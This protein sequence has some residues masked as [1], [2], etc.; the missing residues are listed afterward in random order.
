[1]TNGTEIAGKARFDRIRYAQCWEDADVLLE[2]MQV[3]KGDTCLS[4]ASAGDNT[5][6]LAGAGAGRVIAVDLNPAQIA[7]LELRIAAYRELDHD[8]FLEI[9]GQSP[10][11]RREQLY[12]RCRR[13]LSVDSC[14]FWDCRRVLIRRGF[15]QVGKFERFLRSFRRYLLPLVE[16]RRNVDHL[17]ALRTSQERQAFYDSRWNNRRWRFLCRLFFGRAALGRFGRDPS[18]TRYADESVWAS[19]QRRIPQALVVQEPADNPYLQWILKG[20]Y[21]SALPWSWRRENFERIRRNLDAIEWHCEPIEQVLAGIPDGTLNGCNLSDIF[22]Y[23]SETAYRALLYEFIRASA[24]GCRLVYW[25]VVVERSRPE[26]FARALVPLKALA[27]RLHAVDKA[28]FYRSLV[29]EEV[30]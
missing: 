18:F 15:A 21:E 8:E 11:D 20:R 22:E 6:A 26:M 25:N 14:R 4:I 1:M 27:D 16:G 7:C 13:H 5:I 12:T 10:S 30:A 29:V 23:M 3:A 2:A 9:V 19:L 24:P 17:L 28:F